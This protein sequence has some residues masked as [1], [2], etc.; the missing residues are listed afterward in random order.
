MGSIILCDL[1][2]VSVYAFQERNVTSWAESRL[3]ELVAGA[4]FVVPD[5]LGTV[6]E[7]TK[8]KDLSGDASIAFSRGR[9]K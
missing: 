9:K 5:G 1:T 8:V 2:R 4:N 6:I 3:R 7:V